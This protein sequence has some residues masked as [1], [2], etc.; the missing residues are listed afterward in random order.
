L[1]FTPKGFARARRGVSH[2]LVFAPA[3]SAARAVISLVVALW[4][5]DLVA[6]D[7]S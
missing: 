1:G 3:L 7:Y 2:L 6:M 4:L 5:G